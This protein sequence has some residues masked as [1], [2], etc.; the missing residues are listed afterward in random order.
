MLTICIGQRHLNL[1]NTLH[2]RQKFFTSGS[3]FRLFIS[4]K[5]TRSK[6]KKY[7]SENFNKA[8]AARAALLGRGDDLVVEPPDPVKEPVLECVEEPVLEPAPA[9]VHGPHPASAPVPVR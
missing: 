5:S 6:G 4:K 1:P 8:R 3:D 7:R 9:P 2:Y